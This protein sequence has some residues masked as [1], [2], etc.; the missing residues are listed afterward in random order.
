MQ[1]TLDKPYKILKFYKNYISS[2]GNN[3]PKKLISFAKLLLE[4]KHKATTNSKTK[5][6]HITDNHK[7][8]DILE[9]K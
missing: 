8:L 1:F 4:S 3:H 9:Q 2:Y 5:A 6:L 7:K